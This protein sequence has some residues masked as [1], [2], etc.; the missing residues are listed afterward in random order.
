MTP[1]LHSE[2]TRS[3][4]DA[5]FTVYNRLGY[6]FIESH[7]ASSMERKLRSLGLEVSREHAVRVYFEGEEIGFHRVDMVINE[8]VV[9]EL[10]SGP[11]VPTY[12]RA[13]LRN[14]LKATNLEVGILLHFGPAPRFEKMFA[15]NMGLGRIQESNNPNPENNQ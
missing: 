10:K 3:I 6:G 15:L 14:Y 9:V 1:E 11:T 4:I 2:I 8:C 5:F 12:A 13:Q 7:Y